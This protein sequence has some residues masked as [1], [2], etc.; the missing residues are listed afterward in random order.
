MRLH[1]VYG[2]TPKNGQFLSQSA[3]IGITPSHSTVAVSHV[4]W[5]SVITGSHIISLALP[6]LYT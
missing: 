4:H 6:R 2:S 3:D 5:K 1:C